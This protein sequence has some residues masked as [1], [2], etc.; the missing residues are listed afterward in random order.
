MYLSY[1]TK[2]SKKPMV[3]GSCKKTTHFGYRNRRLSMAQALLYV[4]S[5]FAMT[6]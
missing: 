2:N 3:L 4:Y 5:K 1:Y 6:F